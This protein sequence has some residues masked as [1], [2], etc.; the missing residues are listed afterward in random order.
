MQKEKHFILKNASVID[1]INGATLE[2]R[3]VEVED[4]KI[5]SIDEERDL[6][7]GIKIIDIHGYFLSP[8]LINI[9]SGLFGNGIP[10]KNYVEK[11][12]AKKEKAKE[13]KGTLFLKGEAKKSLRDALN[14]GVTTIAIKEDAPK[15]KEFIELKKE[16]LPIPTIMEID[17]EKQ[18]K[19]LSLSNLYGIS[20]LD[21]EYSLASDE[22]IEKADKALEEIKEKGLPIEGI[23]ND[24][25]MLFSSQGGMWRELFYLQ[26]TFDCTALDVL[27]LATI[28]NA[29]LLGIRDRTGSIEVG[30][31]ADMIITKHSPLESPLA[32]RRVRA[33]IRKN[34]I[35]YGPQPKRD[36]DL[37]MELDAIFIEPSEEETIHMD[38][39]SMEKMKKK[40]KKVHLILG[41]AVGIL[42]II[43]ILIIVFGALIVSGK[44]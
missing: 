39:E 13:G 17:E 28:K 10:K 5:V 41:I 16:K 40:D 4:G 18:A 44:I 14:S 37:E 29:E 23:C 21:K 25:G 3:F 43:M 38:P 34:I 7:L 9:R 19:A 30:K 1:V 33:T 24:G 11:L 12:K 8:G 31:D 42:A 32:L 36:E 26:K 15:I 35:S 22:E 6:P 20:K 27:R 2:N